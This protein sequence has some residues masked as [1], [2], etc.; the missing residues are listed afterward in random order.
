MI[1]TKERAE[2]VIRQMVQENF[3]AEAAYSR[4]LKDGQVTSKVTVTNNEIKSE[5]VEMWE[6]YRR[7]PDEDGGIRIISE[8]RFF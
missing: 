5:F 6:L 3:D 7:V 4:L 2:A 8:Y 1:T